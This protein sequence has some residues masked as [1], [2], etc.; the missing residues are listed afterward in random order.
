MNDADLP[1]SLNRASDEAGGI[2]PDTC[3]LSEI[4]HAL[5]PGRF[6]DP[7]AL[8][9][10]ISMKSRITSESQNVSTHCIILVVCSPKKRSQ[11]LTKGNS[12][13]PIYR[14]TRAYKVEC[15]IIYIV[16]EV[17]NDL[18]ANAIKS[19]FDVTLYFLFLTK[20]TTGRRHLTI[21]SVRSR[22]DDTQMEAKVYGTASEGMVSDD[23]GAEAEELEFIRQREATFSLVVGTCCCGRY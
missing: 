13:Y 23:V 1:F 2:C 16:K 6:E 14:Q 11:I 18:I 4:P 10:R 7:V 15:G 19:D 12:V 22:S 8:P 5:P 17:E 9:S 3:C 20:R 21:Y